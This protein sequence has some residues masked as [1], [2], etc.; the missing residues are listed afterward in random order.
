[1]DEKLKEATNSLIRF[2]AGKC[3]EGPLNSL[4]VNSI[5]KN[6][7]IN[8]LK[9]HQVELTLPMVDNLMGGE[10]NPQTRL[11]PKWKFFLY[12]DPDGLYK[13]WVSL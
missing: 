10:F 7:K 3:S 6:L 11:D 8:A 1:M 13:N 12:F 5:K 2:M 9:C 4:W